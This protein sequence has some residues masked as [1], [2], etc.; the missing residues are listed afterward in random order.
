MG[1]T[2]KNLKKYAQYLRENPDTAIK[3]LLRISGRENTDSCWLWRGGKR[4]GKNP[5]VDIDGHSA[6]LHG[7]LAYYF[8]PQLSSK[9][10]VTMCDTTNCLNPWHV[11]SIPYVRKPKHKLGA[12]QEI[13]TRAFPSHIARICKRGHSVIGPNIYSITTWNKNTIR[14]QM[15]CRICHYQYLRLSLIHISEPT[16]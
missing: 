15:K 12:S 14:T 4:G 13:I 6:K 16:R 7:V 5:V 3:I 2:M 11:D 1:E 9:R 8:I 10:T